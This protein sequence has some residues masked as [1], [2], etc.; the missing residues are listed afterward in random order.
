MSNLASR[1]SAEIADSLSGVRT[2]LAAFADRF[3]VN[4]GVRPVAALHNF[5]V[6]T[7]MAGIAAAEMRPRSLRGYGPFD[8]ET[9]KAIEDA[10]DDLQNALRRVQELVDN[11]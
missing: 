2:K 6:Q 10:C 8:S 11:A 1:Q 4:A 5:K 9:A 7:T 3:H